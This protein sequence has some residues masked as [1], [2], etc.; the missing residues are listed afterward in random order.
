MPCECDVCTWTPASPRRRLPPP[1][2]EKPRRVEPPAF[3]VRF[4]NPAPHADV[5]D[6][7]PPKKAPP[8]PQPAFSLDRLPLQHV[9]GVLLII[10]AL[11]ASQLGGAAPVPQPSCGGACAARYAPAPSCARDRASCARRDG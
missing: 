9:I 4:L 3:P 6:T 10:I 11:L 7:L 8:P 2:E 5:V 1:C